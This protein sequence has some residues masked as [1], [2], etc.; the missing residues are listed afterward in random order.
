MIHGKK[1]YKC[2]ICSGSWERK[3]HYLE[4][5]KT[6]KHSKNTKLINSIQIKEESEKKF[7]EIL[8]NSN[9][10]LLETNKILKKYDQLINHLITENTRLI[11][12]I[13]CLERKINLMKHENKTASQTSYNTQVNVNN[14]LN[15]VT[16]NVD[17]RAFGHEN[18]EHLSTDT[19][20]PIMK[21]V[22]SAIPEIVKILHFSSE[23]PENHNIKITNKKLN[24]VTVFDGKTWSTRDKNNTL[25]AIVSNIVDKLETNYE[26]DFINSS[27]N[28]VQQLW[29]I[30]R[31]RAD[32]KQQKQIK[33]NVEFVLYDN[34]KMII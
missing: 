26:Y 28:H 32:T 21:Q 10:E 27:S 1:N 23:H 4:H 9:K 30:L 15:L 20:I 18:W 11:K 29:Q 7:E 34:R 25:E 16:Y 2:L 12:Q 24:H 6:K 8:P 17:L 19:I 33:T 14:N 22:N 5:L 13:E 3:C 31:D